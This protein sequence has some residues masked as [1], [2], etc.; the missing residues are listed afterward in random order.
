[1]HKLSDFHIASTIV[2]S[3]CR[4]RHCAF[5]DI[6]VLFA[7]EKDAFIGFDGK[8]LNVG[9]PKNIG[10]TNYLLSVQYLKNFQQICGIPA[11]DTDAQSKNAISWIFMYIQ[12]LINNGKDTSKNEPFAMRL[13]QN[14]LVWILMKDIVCPVY[15][16]LLENIKMILFSSPYSDTR[17]VKKK[18]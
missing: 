2:K 5:V 8:S 18:N 10:E 3:V 7:G 14:P 1:M 6:P 17:L 9:S 16:V 13:Y 11:W 12:G 4:S 15:E